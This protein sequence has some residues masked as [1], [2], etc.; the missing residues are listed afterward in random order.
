MYVTPN[1]TRN[2][3]II[4]C[5]CRMSLLKKVATKFFGQI[6]KATTVSTRPVSFMV[7]HGVSN[8]EI[9]CRFVKLFVK[10]TANV[11]TD[12]TFLI[13]QRK[14][15]AMASQH[16]KIGHGRIRM[17]NNYLS[18]IKC[19]INNFVLPINIRIYADVHIRLL[20]QGISSRSSKYYRAR[21][22]IPKTTLLHPI[23][24]LSRFECI[25]NRQ[26]LDG[27]DLRQAMNDIFA[28]DAVP[29]PK[30]VNAALGACRRNNDYSLAV[31]FL[32]G[33]IDRMGS[34]KEK[35]YPYFV[36]EISSTLRELGCD[37]PEDLGYDKPELF[38]EDI[39]NLSLD[40]K[41]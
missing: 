8:E 4:F 21:F 12:N 22:M 29:D 32:E 20:V 31:R 23:P 19:A 5:I 40:Q 34:D 33:C 6:S 36:Q 27:W 39:H 28:L 17:H 25:F 41:K 16:K 1:Q 11:S 10:F 18:I 37:L 7:F 26:D 30:V 14:D 15:D 13:E 38:L 2:I 24:V 9:S 3:I 35:M